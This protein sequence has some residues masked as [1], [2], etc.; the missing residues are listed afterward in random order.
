MEI[1]VAVTMLMQRPLPIRSWRAGLVV[2]T[3]LVVVKTTPE[4]ALD[5]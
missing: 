1:L 5:R 2:K 4:R 3:A